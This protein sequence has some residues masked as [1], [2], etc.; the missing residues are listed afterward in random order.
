M[1]NTL[2][3][4]T[5]Q[6][7]ALTLADLRAAWASHF[8]IA[9]SSD[10]A[11]PIAA[12]AALVK[13][14]VDKGDPAYGINTGFGILAKAHIRND[15]LE[16]LQRNLILS[17]AVGTGELISDAVVRMILLT[18]IGSLARV[19]VNDS[20]SGVMRHADAGYESAIACAKRTG[21]NLPMIK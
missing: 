20:G 4:W 21:L 11:A 13:T 6:P 16:Q 15:Q 1:T 7:G 12:S 2:Q 5:L 8:T 19:L 17:H 14:I 10:A 9:L 3:H 18:K